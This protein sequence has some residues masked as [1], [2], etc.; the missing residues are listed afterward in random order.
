MW[1]HEA[2]INFLRAAGLAVPALL[3][4]AVGFRHDCV[5]VDVLHTVDLGVASHV[6]ANVM[7]HVAV[8]KKAFGGATQEQQIQKMYAHMQAWYSRTKAKR[9]VHGEDHSRACSDKGRL[10]EAEG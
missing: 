8:L 2:Y 5:M 7:W 3:A 9:K 6:I 4:L 1:R 10:V